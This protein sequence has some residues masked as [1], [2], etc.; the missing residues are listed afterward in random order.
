MPSRNYRGEYDNYHKKT[1]QK[2][3]EPVGTQPDQL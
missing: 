2:K 1:E 3:E